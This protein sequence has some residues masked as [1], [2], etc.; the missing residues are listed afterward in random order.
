MVN[1]DSSFQELEAETRVWFTSKKEFHAYLKL[2]LFPQSLSHVIHVFGEVPKRDQSVHS[3]I[4]ENVIQPYAPRQTWLFG[5][6][7]TF[8][9]NIQKYDVKCV[10]GF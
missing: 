1:I 5:C 4:R 10:V 8:I 9:K 7:D 2:V 6:S 3:E